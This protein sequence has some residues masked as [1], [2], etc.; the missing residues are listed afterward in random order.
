MKPPVYIAAMERRSNTGYL[1]FKKG[2]KRIGNERSDLLVSRT[3]ACYIVQAV[4]HM[5]TTTGSTM[6]RSLSHMYEMSP[7]TIAIII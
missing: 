7:S 3:K 1:I 2:K 6:M 5:P 4:T